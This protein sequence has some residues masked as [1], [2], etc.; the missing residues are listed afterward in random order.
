MNRF[1]LLLMW[2]FAVVLNFPSRHCFMS[3][4]LISVLKN[5]TKDH[6]LHKKVGV[7]L[8]NYFIFSQLPVLFT[9]TQTFESEYVK[10]E[11]SLYTMM[12]LHYTL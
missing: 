4:N 6:L 8:K 9:K 11:T 12:R 3:Y 10:H 2:L 5:P 1:L 7:T